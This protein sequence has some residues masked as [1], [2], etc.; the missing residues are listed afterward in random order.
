MSR[1]KPR[2]ED[3]SQAEPKPLN[4]SAT[5]SAVASVP[6]ILP[7]LPE[8]RAEK[9]SLPIW[10]IVLLFILLYWGDMY[11][12]DH[13]ADLAGKAGAFPAVVYDPFHSYGELAQANPVSP[14]Q[15]ERNKG[16]QVF[17]FVCVQCHQANGQG[18]P[19]QFPP[20]AGSEW[21]HESPNRLIRIV[22]NGITG[23]IDVK[24]QAFNN[25]MPPWKGTLND[26][27]IAHV[28]SFVRKEWGNNAPSIT[29]EEVSKVRAETK[30]REAPF[31]A[32]ELR[33][34]PE[35]VAK[36]PNSAQ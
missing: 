15:E 12:M 28:L 34:I 24:G 23:P 2:N 16:Q 32:P 33:A 21:V 1:K 22:L 13:G 25:T 5:A 17:N 10:L 11:I 36:G 35:Q 31:T 20:L 18:V 26:E 6:T 30:S 4:G 7:E 19:G 27:Q 8:P 14:E 9:R 29:P 3:Q